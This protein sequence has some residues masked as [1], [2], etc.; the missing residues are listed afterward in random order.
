MDKYRINRKNAIPL[1]AA[2]REFLGES[3]L[4]PGMNTRRIFAAWDAASG[5]GPQ[6][7]KRYFRSGKLYITL[8]SSVVRSQLSARHDELLDSINDILSR[9]EWFVHDDPSVSWVQELILK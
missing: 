7:L 3:R 6:T 5:A 1:S 8:R 9:D 2:I 4:T